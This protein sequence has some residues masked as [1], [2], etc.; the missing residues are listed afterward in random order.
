MGNFLPEKFKNLTV[1]YTLISL[2]EFLSDMTLVLLAKIP[3]IAPG[4]SERWKENIAM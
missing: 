1:F 2:T 3:H 4:K